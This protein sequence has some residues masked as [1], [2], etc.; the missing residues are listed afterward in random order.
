MSGAGRGVGSGEGGLRHTSKHESFS[1][2]QVSICFR[3]FGTC[4]ISTVTDEVSWKE[5]GI[6]ILQLSQS[7]P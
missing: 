5:Y 1:R 2:G 7:L 3:P 4:L 6:I